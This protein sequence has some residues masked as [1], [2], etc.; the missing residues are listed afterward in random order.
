LLDDVSWVIK[1]GIR[2]ALVGPNGAGKTTLLRLITGE[3][4][5]R[6]GS[7]I[8]ANDYRIGYLPQEEPAA[9][10]GSLLELV[11]QGHREVIE[12]EQRIEEIQQKL[13]DHPGQNELISELGKLQDR[14]QL[15]GGYSL[16]SEAKKI[17]AG[18]GF[19]NEDHSKKLAT[20][21]GGWRMRG[22]LARLLLQQPDLLLLDEPTNHLDLPSLE[23]LEDYLRD[24][25]GSLVIVS[26]D[27]FF[28]ER[29][30]ME[31]AELRNGRLRVYPGSY[32]DFE[33]K[34]QL[35]REQAIKAL[36][37]QRAER[38]QT[39]QF[40]DRFRYKASKAAQVQS[41]IKM[42][43]KM[44]DIELPEDDPRAIS[45]KIK[46]DVKS[47]REVLAA[48]N[49]HF[50]YGDNHVLTGLDWR[51]ERGDKVA[52]V[53]ENGAGKTTLTRLISGELKPDNGSMRIGERVNIGYYA[54]HQVDALNLENTIIDEVTENA[55]PSLRPHVRDILGVFRLSGDD[56]NKKIAVLS[57]GEKARVSLAKILLSPCNFLIMDE[58]TNH[59]DLASREALEQALRDYDG[60]LLVISHDRYFLDRLVHRV[61]ALHD[62]SLKEYLGN[63]SSYLE[64][65]RRERQALKTEENNQKEKAGNGG[66]GSA[67]KSKEQ[68]RQEAEARQAVSK[69]RRGLESDIARLEQKIETLHAEKSGIENELANPD[70]YNDPQK[71]AELNKRLTALEEKLGK[72]ESSWE[73]KQLT[74]EELLEQLG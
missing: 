68:R 13:K 31:I 1:P 67:R 11:L 54:Q 59:L 66:G 50:A 61:S 25:P 24:F 64:R 47:Y 39:Q 29:L 63:Y 43:E 57:G 17:L 71:A 46:T 55:A 40:I 18:L 72:L 10:S 42:M 4:T 73:E 35:Q 69:Q 30:A 26:H 36:E 14:F 33:A 7:M 37:K 48:E 38:K 52:L 9:V 62:G 6:S 2:S 16:E 41:R 23:W 21:S 3:L 60:T 22:H 12:T 20:F 74:Y 70:T 19:K 5:P 65:R 8:K 32:H 56:V 44:E 45:F 58:P 15:L 28:I 51:I 27:R 49:V 53:G 34:K